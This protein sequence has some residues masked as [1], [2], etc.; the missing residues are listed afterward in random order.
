M[1]P[2]D[3]ECWAKPHNPLQG[4]F[5]EHPYPMGGEA[6]SKEETASTKPSE[7]NLSTGLLSR[8]PWSV[9]AGSD[10][11][12]HQDAQVHFL[13]GTWS[14]PLTQGESS[15]SRPHPP[16]PSAPGERTRS[17]AT[18]CTDHTPGTPRGCGG[19]A[20]LQRHSPPSPAPRNV[21]EERLPW[22]S[23]KWALSP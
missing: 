14:G 2:W 20:V 1:C 9:R 23:L 15:M 10:L 11:L 6:E 12:S 7:W 4:R 16:A 19:R 21:D 8:F 22:V 5:C 13:V 18:E 3:L 17:V